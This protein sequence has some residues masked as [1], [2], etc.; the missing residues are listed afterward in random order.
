MLHSFE[1][2]SVVPERYVQTEA[3][4]FGVET[5][6]VHDIAGE[7]TRQGLLTRTVDNRRLATTPEVLNDE[8]AVLSFAREGRQAANPLNPNWQPRADWLSDEQTSAIAQLTSSHD[9]V[10]LLLGGAGTGKTTL[11]QEA[12]EAIK[13]GGHEVFTFAPS[14]EASRKVLREEGFETATTVAELLVN[15]KLQAAT[16][17]HV[18][19]ID[20]ASLLGSRQL[21]P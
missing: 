16:K 11:M 13:E 18:I 2:D 17:D 14:A 21:R 12:V 3:L 19:W 15:E 8:R 5:V 4:R 20:E 10:Q 1:R 6:D 9:R 7:L